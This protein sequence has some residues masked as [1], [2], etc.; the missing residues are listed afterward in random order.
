MK[1]LACPCCANMA[2]IRSTRSGIVAICGTCG[3]TF[4]ETDDAVV[5]TPAAY[6]DADFPEQEAQARR[7]V[8]QRKQVYEQHLGRELRS[9]IEVG[10][11][12]GAWAQAWQDVGCSWL[13]IELIPEVAQTARDRTG[14]TV[15]TGDFVSIE[16]I[17][18]ADVL[19]CSQVLEHVASPVPFLHR[20]REVAGLIHID[21]PNQQSLIAT[22]RRLLGA[23]DYGFIQRPF[24]LRAYNADSLRY[25]M[26]VAGFDIRVC[27]GVAN[28]H[29][30]FGQLS[31]RR[32]LRH[33]IAYRAAEAVGRGSLLMAIGS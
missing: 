32:E 2:P 21:V 31:A 12:T 27:R 13:G 5:A 24:H 20:A 22:A 18:K 15:L 1:T 26:S 17:P 16:A 9:V 30:V 14:A 19:F 23:T 3:L 4:C 29:A 11:G 25:A 10:C 6:F 7:M 8:G 33:R 28:D